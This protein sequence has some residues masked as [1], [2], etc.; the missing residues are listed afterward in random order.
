MARLIWL[1]IV[2]PMSIAVK[3]DSFGGNLLGHTV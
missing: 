3:D 2:C 1:R